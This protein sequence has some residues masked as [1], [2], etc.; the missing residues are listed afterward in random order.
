MRSNKLQNLKSQAPDP[1]QPRTSPRKPPAHKLP[2]DC[3]SPRSSSDSYTQADPSDMKA[4]DFMVLHMNISPTLKSQ[5]VAKNRRQ[6]TGAAKAIKTYG[7]SPSLL[8][9]LGKPVDSPVLPPGINK[10]TPLP[11]V[12]GI[13]QE[14]EAAKIPSKTRSKLTVDPSGAA[15][16]KTQ[17]PVKNPDYVYLKGE[18]VEP[19]SRRAHGMPMRAK[20]MKQVYDAKHLGPTPGV[21]PNAPSSL[22]ASNP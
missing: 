14:K 13:L 4:K 21:A 19:L 10:P 22:R 8:K 1:R 17:Q 7:G 6:I 20:Q 2:H 11:T 18:P 15:K 16:V 5:T 9:T 3:P 12:I